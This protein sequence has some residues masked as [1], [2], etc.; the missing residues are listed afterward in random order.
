MMSIKKRAVDEAIASLGYLKP[1][2]APTIMAMLADIS[3]IPVRELVNSYR[4]SGEQLTADQKRA[5]GIRANANMSQEAFSELTESGVD[6]ALQ[7]HLVTLLRSRNTFDR[8]RI[9]E[10]H[11]GQFSIGYRSNKCARC[12]QFTETPVEFYDAP[13]FPP[14]GCEEN[15]CPLSIIPHVD[16]LAGLRDSLTAS[17]RKE[18][19][20]LMGDKEGKPRFLSRLFNWLRL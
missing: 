10:Q 18:V 20:R 16:H 15:D 5:N 11:K 1:S 3:T 17:E 6:T 9:K 12:R 14:D 7:A 8:L 19:L 13:S 4:K 2:A